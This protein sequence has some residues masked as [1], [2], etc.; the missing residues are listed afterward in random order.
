MTILNWCN[1]FGLV[2]YSSREVSSVVVK[3]NK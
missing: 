2:G 3:Y 1:G